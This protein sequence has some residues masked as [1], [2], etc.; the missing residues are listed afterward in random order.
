MYNYIKIPDKF[1]WHSLFLKNPWLP[2][3]SSLYEWFKMYNYFH[4]QM[5]LSCDNHGNILWIWESVQLSFEIHRIRHQKLTN[6]P[7]VPAPCSLHDACTPMS[8]LQLTADHRR[9]HHRSSRWPKR[10]HPMQREM[11]RTTRIVKWWRRE[12]VTPLLLIGI[13]MFACIDM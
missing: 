8:P 11:D 6:L 7:Y 5:L 2:S 13:S 4:F 1:W 12:L 10:L 3:I 9:L